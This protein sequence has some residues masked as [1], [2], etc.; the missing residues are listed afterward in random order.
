MSELLGL[1]ALWLREVKVYSRERSRIASSVF[2]PIL[3][4]F[5]FGKGL[6]A[7]ISI[8][9]LAYDI[10]LYPGIIAMS[11]LFTSLFFGVY[12]VWDK[13]VDFLKEVLVSPL[14][15]TTVFLGKVLGG[16][17]DTI[18]QVTILLLLAPFLGIS[19]GP[20]TI[21]LIYGTVFFLSLGIVS[22]GLIIGSVME[23]PEG[24]GLVVSFVA[25]PLFFLSGALFPIWNLPPWLRA[26]VM[27]D[28]V[29]YGVD[30]LRTVILGGGAIPLEVS[31]AV[32][33]AFSAAMVYIGT[34]AFERMKAY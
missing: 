32:L 29:T 1:Y 17:T 24:F 10:F 4:L 9:G 33:T 19:I 20:R 13:R 30:A 6:G 12:I 18:I 15:R 34:K 28:P 5:V 11:T 26:F 16:M 27:L 2:T 25:Y 23:S 22:I 31:F 8:G 7:T 3:W 21:V 14:S